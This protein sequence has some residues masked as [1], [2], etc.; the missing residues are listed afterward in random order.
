M[1]P[2]NGNVCHSMTF[3]VASLCQPRNT[4]ERQ[5]KTTR[6]GQ[7]VGIK[8]EPCS[9]LQHVAKTKTDTLRAT[10][11]QENMTSSNM[12]QG[13]FFGGKLHTGTTFWGKC[14]TRHTKREGQES[15]SKKTLLPD[16]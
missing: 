2:S 1:P 7:T 13:M 15:Q 5:T 3:S 10:V 6:L 9:S 11:R 4:S 16:H 12:P 14:M 8:D